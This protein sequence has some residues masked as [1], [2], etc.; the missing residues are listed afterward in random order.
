MILSAGLTPAWQQ[1]LVFESFRY[2]EV[3]RA[4]EAHWCASGKVFN[5]G[6][7]VHHLGAESLTLAVAG[8]PPL[9]QIRAEMQ[10]L[11]VP[12]DVVETESATRVCTTILDRSTGTMT[13]LVENGR[14]VS[15]SELDAFEVR[16]AEKANKAGVVILIG[17]LP[18]GTPPTYYRRLLQHVTCPTVLDIRGEGLLGVLD[19]EP[20]IIKPNREELAQTV[21]HELASDEALIDAMRSLNE[22]GAQWVVITDGPDSVWLTSRTETWRF[23]PPS[24][25][26]AEVVNPI[27]CG[28][29]MAAALAKAVSDGIPIPEAL[30]F[31]IAASVD[32]LHQLL[33]CRLDPSRIRNIADSIQS[34][35]L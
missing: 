5:A 11:G 13:E 34:Q 23:Q 21:G 6:I 26:K 7:G 19:L 24:V 16:F 29:S 25:P 20:T 1:I 15:E 22:R 3:N 27:G 2:G 9:V 17:T 10:S 28:D 35:R 33:P 14:P 8:G 4:A 12:I 30:R 31:G 32:N 18:K